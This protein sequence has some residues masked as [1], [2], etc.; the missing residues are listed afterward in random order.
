MLGENIVKKVEK[1]VFMKGRLYIQYILVL[2]CFTQSS[3]RIWPLVG[4]VNYNGW[5]HSQEHVHISKLINYSEYKDDIKAGCIWWMQIWEELVGLMVDD[6]H[7]MTF[8]K[9]LIK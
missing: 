1:E 6:M 7:S 3:L 5:S 2:L 9:E 8:F 4:Q